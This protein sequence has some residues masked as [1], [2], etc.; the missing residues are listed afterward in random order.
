MNLKRSIFYLAFICS[1]LILA[2]CDDHYMYN[3][4]D[5]PEWLGSSIYDYLN[6][7]GE[8]K[9]YARL[10][11]DVEGYYDILSQT[12]SKT[13]F[14]AKDSAFTEFFKD[15]PWGV[16]SY[17][18][19]SD[20][21]KKMILKYGMINNA[22]LIQTLSNYFDGGSLVEGTA[23]RRV[24]AYSYLDSIP[25][26]KGNQIPTVGKFW[27]PYTERG[28]YLAK[29]NSDYP[30]IHFLQSQIVSDNITP[31]DFETIVGETREEGD[32]HLFNIKIID[33][34][35]TC[36]NGYIHVLDKVLI[37]RT[38]M[39]DYVQNS[40]ETT[41]FASIL[42]RFCAP[43]YNAALT[44]EY[45]QLH[46]EFDD[47]IFV[48]KFYTIPTGG[49]RN[50]YPNLQVI[51]N[52]SYLL[53]FDPG[54]N[55]YVPFGTGLNLQNDMGALLIP[56]DDAMDYYFNEGS[57]RLLKERY[58]SWDA[59]P[60][61]I[62]A[63]FVKRHMR[64][65]FLNSL[66][67]TFPKMTDTENSKIFIEESN[68]VD[69]YLGVNGVV[70]ITDKVFPPDDYVSVYG[71]VL[72]SED[73]KI[74]NWVIRQNNFRLYLNAM[75]GDTTYTFFVPTDDVLNGYIDPYTLG[76]NKAG[77]LKFTYDEEEDEVKCNCIYLRHCE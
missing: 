62:A 45:K 1:M 50:V 57:G 16:S 52:T 41:V 69:T 53:N 71:P 59:L 33:Q 2:S 31:S 48:K 7:N 46:D 76:K 61:D 64:A 32:A 36:K 70:Y 11:N 37:P 63:L 8:Y 73:T 56:N 20:S 60:M 22:Y 18:E 75:V 9:Y 13:L 58:G 19:L 3:D 44:Q 17:E 10:I 34:D 43:Y 51:S 40:D 67:S 28:L 38:N 54:W 47:S 74:M 23:M 66:P 30:L 15:N 26:L 49:G 55:S 6:E 29:D 12:G 5:D 24:S 35:I 21:Q 77:A 25:F 4:G 27:T 72:F 65:S 39:A 68:V 14:V 42:D